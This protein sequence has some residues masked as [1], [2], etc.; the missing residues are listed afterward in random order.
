MKRAK[1]M[2][3]SNFPLMPAK[4][5]HNNRKKRRTR[6]KWLFQQQRRWLMQ[7]QWQNQRRSKKMR[8]K[9]SIISAIQATAI[10]LTWLSSLMA[11]CWNATRRISNQNIFPSTSDSKNSYW[12][13]GSK[14]NDC[15]WKHIMNH[16]V[17]S[18][19]FD[20]LHFLLG[21]MIDVGFGLN[22]SLIRR[23]R[24]LFAETA[25]KR[26]IVLVDCLQ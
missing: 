6:L 7:H 16:L 11:V 1:P 19:S 9:L 26:S 12:R 5:K 20:L 17:K 14:K 18:S 13:I 24:L 10:W 22:G 21:L 15:L 8:S 2:K 4:K 25:I 23:F 3:P